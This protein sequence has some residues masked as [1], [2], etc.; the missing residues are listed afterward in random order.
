MDFERIL[1]VPFF[2]AIKFSLFHLMH[3][4]EVGQKANKYV[5]VIYE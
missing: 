5:Y 2:L 4:G 3:W 1:D